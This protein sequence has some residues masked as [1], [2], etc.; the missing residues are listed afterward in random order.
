MKI[1]NLRWLS[2]SLK[3]S[4]SLLHKK[5]Y[6]HYETIDHNASCYGLVPLSR[7]KTQLWPACNI[8]HKGPS[9]MSPQFLEDL[10]VVAQAAARPHCFVLKA[11]KCQWMCSFYLM[12]LTGIG[13]NFAR[14][15]PG[16]KPGIDP[17]FHLFCLLLA[18]PRPL[19][20]SF[21]SP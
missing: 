8:R 7:V 15:G 12:Y 21:P 6:I 14:A 1:S 2:F 5:F 3:L 20:C 11:N 13:L 17:D 9:H 19:G 10:E 16:S 18:V 4:L